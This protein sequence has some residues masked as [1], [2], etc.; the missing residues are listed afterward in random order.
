MRTTRTTGKKKI[1]AS[2]IKRQ[3]TVF[4]NTKGKSSSRGLS[5]MSVAEKEERKFDLQFYC[6]AH[7]AEVLEITLI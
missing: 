1:I 7:I 5:C 2:S 4:G 6:F 3:F